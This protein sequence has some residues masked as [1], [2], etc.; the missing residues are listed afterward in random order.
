MNPETLLVHS[1]P[2]VICISRLFRCACN[3]SY[4]RRL[5]TCDP[6]RPQPSPRI[7]FPLFR[8]CSI[9]CSRGLCENSLAQNETITTIHRSID[10]KRFKRNISDTWFAINIVSILNNVQNCF[11]GP[12][13]KRHFICRT[14]WSSKDYH[15]SHRH[16][17][18]KAFTECKT[19]S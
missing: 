12:L 16:S 13:N 4:I 14:V 8:V 11:D 17:K 5:R 15:S 18:I 3:L 6:V 2:Y 10:P 7:Y 9:F 19:S 1:R